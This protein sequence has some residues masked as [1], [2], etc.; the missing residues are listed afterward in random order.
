MI[1]KETEL[2]NPVKNYLTSL[3]FKVD[4]EVKDCDV[5]ASKDDIIVICELKRGFTIELLYQLVQRKKLTPFVYA[6]IPRPKNMRRK[7]FVKKLDLL[8]ALE[9][10]LMVV[11]NSTKRVDIILEPK[12]EDTIS[13]K[14]SRKSIEKEIKSRNLS[15]NLGGQNK[16]KIVTAHK[17]SLIATLC[18]IEKYG[19]IRTRDCKQNIRDIVQR[20][21][22]GYFVR[23]NRGIYTA[24][25]D[26]M[27]I[28]QDKDYKDIVEYYRNEVNLC[29]K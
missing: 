23:I 8:R 19:E 1:E 20:N 10:G 5:V 16:R 2:Y 18:Y 7:D 9:C 6:V 27:K 14:K 15:L 13:N 29:L 25:S 24:K 22:Y 21:H 26:A 4:A 12:G 17:E 11:L 3:G 28:L